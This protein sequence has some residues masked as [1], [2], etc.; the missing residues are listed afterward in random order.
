MME[1]RLNAFN[2]RTERGTWLATSLLRLA[3][4]ELKPIWRGESVRERH[5]QNGSGGEDELVLLTEAAAFEAA[6]RAAELIRANDAEAL[7]AQGSGAGIRGRFY[8]L[9]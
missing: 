1:I 2:A 9:S 4:A 5:V 7:D 3:G 6:N 8:L